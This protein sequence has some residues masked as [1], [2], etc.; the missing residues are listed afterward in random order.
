MEILNN[1]V[2]FKTSSEVILSITSLG[3]VYYRGQLIIH[4]DPDLIEIFK[5]KASVTQPND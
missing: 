3:N 5:G 1:E 4:E 2:V